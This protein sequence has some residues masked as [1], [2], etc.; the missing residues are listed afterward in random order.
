MKKEIIVFVLVALL[1]SCSKEDV[2]TPSYSD[3]N[4]FAVEDNPND[5][6]AN[7]IYQ[8]YKKSG[9]PI[10]YHDLI[11]TEERGYD[12]NGEPIVFEMRLDLNYSITGGP[13][14]PTPKKFTLS[15]DKTAIMEGVKFVDEYLL[16]LVPK[17]F[18]MHSILLLNELYEQPYENGKKTS[19]IAHGAMNTF[20]IADVEL[21]AAMSAEQKEAHANKILTM[22]AVNHLYGNVDDEIQKFYKVS[23]DPVKQWNFYTMM[24]QVPRYP[25]Y[26]SLDPA[27][28]EVYGFLDYDRSYR[29]IDESADLATW[30]YKIVAQKDD[31]EDF[32]EA[33][34]SYTESEFTVKY[35]EY[36]R[37][38]EKYKIM[39]KKVSEMGFKVN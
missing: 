23:Y 7:K 1:F 31:I 37:V 14:A 15:E 30:I 26:K 4:W 3:R 5:P 13:T 6:L 27:R 25:G 9:I 19:F 28:W 20:A 36:P 8:I 32:V 18:Y 22:L 2:L 24:V 10:F 21:I 17:Q 35:N 34:L 38:M 16:P 12:A 29:V 33:V 11:G 39:R